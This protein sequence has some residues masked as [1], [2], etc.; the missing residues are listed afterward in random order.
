MEFF[1][2]LRASRVLATLLIVGTSRL[3]AQTAPVIAQA[4]PELSGALEIKWMRDSEEYAALTRMVYRTA[5]R[6]VGEAARR[7]PRGRA[8]AVVLD[9]DETTLD[10][11]VYQLSRIAYGEA[12]DTASWNDWVR[13][14]QSGVVP[15]VVEFV[16]AMRR[17][18]GKVAY[19]SSRGDMT[20]EPTIVNLRV[21]SLWADD[22]RLCL[23]TA[24]PQYNKAARRAEVTAGSGRCAWDGT[25]LTVL[26]YFGDNIQDFPQAGENDPDAGS[27]AAFGVRFWMLPNPMYGGWVTRPT[28]QAR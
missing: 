10:N 19:I 16:A 22:D 14:K 1:R 21:L 25:P 17:L 5:E 15:G 24:D 28:R 12:F 4:P 3:M 23:L 20:R 13:R 9:L 8:W 11:S 18:G 26:G 27:D 7:L 6:V 2:V